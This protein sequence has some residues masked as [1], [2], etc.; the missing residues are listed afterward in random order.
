VYSS[1]SSGGG[2]F[3]FDNDPHKYLITI[4]VG[5]KNSPALAHKGK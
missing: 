5:G 2:A 1:S 3:I 4:F